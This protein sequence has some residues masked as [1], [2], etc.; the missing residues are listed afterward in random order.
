MEWLPEWLKPAPEIK[1]MLVE[2][3]KPLERLEDTPET[4]TA[5]KTLQHHPGF[6]FLLRKLRLQGQLLETKLRRDRHDN[7]HDVEFIQSGIH[8]ISWLELQLRKELHQPTS[9][10]PVEPNPKESG[11]LHAAMKEIMQ[12]VE[13]VGG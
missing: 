10:T 13:V 6:Q 5:V 1:L 7:M 12:G 2:V 3:P 11:D 9:L 8:W 4:S